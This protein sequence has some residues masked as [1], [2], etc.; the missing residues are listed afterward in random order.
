MVDHHVAFVHQ[1][2]TIND[3]D[4]LRTKYTMVCRLMD[5]LRKKT[6][7][8]VEIHTV[9]HHLWYIFTY[10]SILLPLKGLKR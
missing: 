8:E 1:G 4:N 10:I 9:P 7:I 3:N 2:C 5:C 6:Q